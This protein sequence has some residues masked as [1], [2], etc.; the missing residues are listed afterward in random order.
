MNIDTVAIG[1]PVSGKPWKKSGVKLDR[2]SSGIC[3][4]WNRKQVERKQRDSLRA[5]VKQRRAE[6]GAK[7]KEIREKK[8]EKDDRKKYNEMKSG[9]FQIIRNTAKLKKWNKKNKKMLKKLPADLFYEK[10]GNTL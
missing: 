2:G 4:S 3:K 5:K 9:S 10:F 1:M 6:V 7:L 8:E